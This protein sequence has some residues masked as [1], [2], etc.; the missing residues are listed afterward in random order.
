MQFP[1]L[2]VTA[3]KMRF[4]FS[5]SNYS[6]QMIIFGQICRKIQIFGFKEVR[7]DNHHP[8]HLKEMV[9]PVK[10]PIFWLV[11]NLIFFLPKHF[12]TKKIYLSQRQRQRRKISFPA[13]GPFFQYLIG[14]V[15]GRRVMRRKLEPMS[16]FG[17]EKR[18][19]RYRPAPENEGFPSRP[20]K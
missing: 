9:E 6:K 12:R 10:L 19:T 3:K 8:P 11:K 2:F 13:S 14:S 7:F 15:L 18:L 4:E 5:S 1:I 20:G 17:G 16:P